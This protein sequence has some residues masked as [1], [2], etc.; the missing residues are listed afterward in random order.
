MKCQRQPL[1]ISWQQFIRND[2]VAATTG[3]LSMSLFTAN[4]GYVVHCCLRFVK[5]CFRGAIS[6]DRFNTLVLLFTHK[7]IELDMYARRHPRRM[8]LLN[9]LGLDS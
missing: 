3:L 4:F 2:E 6:E 8:I 5:S 7:D 9:H 1:Q